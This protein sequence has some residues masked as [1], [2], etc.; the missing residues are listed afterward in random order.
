MDQ[1]HLSPDQ[2]DVDTSVDE[3]Q[4]GRLQDIQRKTKST[5]VL[6][7]TEF[8]LKELDFKE[9]DVNAVPTPDEIPDHSETH[10]EI[11]LEIK[12]SATV[13]ALIGQNDDL[14]ARLKVNLRRLTLLE[15]ENDRLRQAHRAFEAKNNALS[16]EKRIFEEKESIWRQKEQ[17]LE[18]IVHDF[19]T[20]LPDY[21]GLAEKLDRYKK[22][23]ERIKTQVKPFIQQLKSYADS[24]M[25]EI[26]KLNA[27]LAE[28]ELTIDQLRQD[29][30]ELVGEIEKQRHQSES[31]QELLVAHYERL[32]Q[33]STVH[34]R[35]LQ[36][37]MGRLEERAQA[38]DEMRAR[39]DE[40][41]N[42]VVA[43]RRQKLDAEREATEKHQDLQ[44]D[45]GQARGELAVAL[46][47]AGD[48]ERRSEL[49]LGEKARIESHN[50]QLEEQ[51][52]S[53]RYLWSAK[54]DDL[55]KARAQLASMEKLNAEL[56]RQLTSLR[57]A[58]ETQ[59]R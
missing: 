11:P 13:E 30:S 12:R 50:Q 8:Q 45:L 48:L 58:A 38:F 17:K 47:R 35:D 53:L 44:N 14:V 52:A 46:E 18:S 43:L 3:V 39:E 37:Q 10:R 5:H 28:R 9:G 29:K 19:R 36:L 20:R 24:L 40:L 7:E 56:S 1:V 57:Q 49:A 42:L 34:V 31:R 25:T 54:S 22:Y 26:Q 23:H 16:D 2:T 21:E 4:F 55:E 15:N 41:S 33:E 32:Q 51:L 27:E 6:Q 59:S